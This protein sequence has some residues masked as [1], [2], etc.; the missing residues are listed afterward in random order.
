VIFEEL[1]VLKFTMSKKQNLTLERCKKGCGLLVKSSSDHSCR[2]E[3]NE[4]LT[5]RYRY[6]APLIDICVS[7]QDNLR[8]PFSIDRSISVEELLSL[9]RKLSGVNN[10][11][12]DWISY[13]DDKM[14]FLKHK[15]LCECNVKDGSQLYYGYQI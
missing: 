10:P 7:T 15:K 11:I 3:L 1:T 12:M 13:F 14:K 6:E 9:I 4:I 8:I 5:K 2:E